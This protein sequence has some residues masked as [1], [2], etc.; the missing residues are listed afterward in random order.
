MRQVEGV[1]HVC[2]RQNVRLSG[3]RLLVDAA[4]RCLAARDGDSLWLEM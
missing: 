3:H 4:L 1:P 2:Q